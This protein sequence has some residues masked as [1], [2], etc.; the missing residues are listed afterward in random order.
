MKGKA[1]F[2]GEKLLLSFVFFN[3]LMA[4]SSIWPRVIAV[5]YNDQEFEVPHS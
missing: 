2:S 3:N 1:I 5:K 4:C